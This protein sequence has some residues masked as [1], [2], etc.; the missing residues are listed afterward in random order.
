[1]AITSHGAGW[2]S[3]ACWCATSPW[4]RR[5]GGSQKRRAECCPGYLAESAR[6]LS[7]IS[8]EDAT[9]S[10]V[11]RRIKRSSHRCIIMPAYS[12]R[13]MA[14]CARVRC[15]MFLPWRGGQAFVELMYIST[16][17]SLFGPENHRFAGLISFPVLD[18]KEVL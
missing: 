13:R 12:Q 14:A 2:R 6:N 10:L 7:W 3:A 5:A 11:P 16:E 15:R 18:R 8:P 4:R 17:L 1:A 9:Y